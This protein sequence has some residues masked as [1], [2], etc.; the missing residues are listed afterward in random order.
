MIN[1]YLLAIVLFLFSMPVISMGQETSLYPSLKPGIKAPPI[2]GKGTDGKV[3]RLS[4][5]K[6]KYTLLYFY[7]VHCHLCAVVTPEL[8]KLYD[9]Y[10]KI[11]LQIVAIPVES[12]RAEWSSYIQEAGLDWLNVFPDAG[13]VDKLKSDYLLTVSPTMYLLDR[14]KI[15]V[16]ERLGRIEHLEEVLNSRIR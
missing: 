11:G 15:L 1:K 7:E 12:D 2:K 14:K 16:T 8:K 9:S 13:T 4:K 6:S 5:V 10:R 3:F